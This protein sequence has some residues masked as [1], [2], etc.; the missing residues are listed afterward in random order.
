MTENR[1]RKM[2]TE[3]KVLEQNNRDMDQRLREI[4][5]LFEKEQGEVNSLYSLFFLL[6]S[7][8]ELFMLFVLLKI[9]KKK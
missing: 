6:H 4:K 3:S 2:R 7:R 9:I 8:V 5:Q 1:T